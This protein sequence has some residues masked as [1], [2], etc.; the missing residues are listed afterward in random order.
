MNSRWL[1]GRRRTVALVVTAVVGS[2][3]AVGVATA[4]GSTTSE[5]LVA[6]APHALATNAKVAAGKSVSYVVSGTATTVPTDATRVQFSVS[7][8]AQ[9]QPGAMT[10]APYLDAADASG[11]SVSWPAA[12]TTVSATLLEPVGVAN[13]VTFTNT[14][15]GSIDVTIKIIGYSTP[16][17]L[18]GRLDS[19]EAT[20]RS[21]SS[22]LAADEAALR[23]TQRLTLVTTPAGNNVFSSTFTGANLLPGSP[24]TMH[25]T[26][27]GVKNSLFVTVAA[28]GTV[29]SNSSLPCSTTDFYITGYDAGSDPIAS[30]LVMKGAGCP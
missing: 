10:A 7:V 24:A 3:L 1:G 19:D 30:N 18:A 6:V 23:A 26:D 9:Q 17:R 13:K 20:I 27:N 28:D 22:R 15:T 4:W 8:A 29:Q 14:S 12:K 21:L 11:D 25:W 16:G 5:G 2:G